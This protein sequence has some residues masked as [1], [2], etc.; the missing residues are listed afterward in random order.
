MLLPGHFRLSCAT[1]DSLLA[2]D[3]AIIPQSAGGCV[4]RATQAAAWSF[5][6]PH[7]SS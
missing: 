1:R 7:A 6:K 2:G 3:N 5:S 4:P